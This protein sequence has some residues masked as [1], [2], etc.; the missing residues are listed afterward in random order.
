MATDAWGE[1]ISVGDK[2][3]AG[4]EIRLQGSSK[5]T[6]VIGQTPHLMDDA[7]LIAHGSFDARFL[8]LAG[9]TM[10]GAIAMGSNKITGLGSG[11]AAGDAVNVGQVVSALSA[12]LLLAGGTMAGAINMGANAL[13][14]AAT[15]GVGQATVQSGFLLDVGGSI[16][17]DGGA[18]TS[19]TTRNGSLCPWTDKRF[20]IE[21]HYDGSDYAL[22]VFGGNEAGDVDAIRFGSYAANEAQQGNFNELAVLKKDGKFGVGLTPTELIHSNAK[23]RADGVFNHNGTDGATGSFDPTAISNVNVSGGLVTGWS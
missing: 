19:S 4:G 21:L 10:S 8:K 18:S 17:A 23:I 12:Y 7:D 3:L 1:T 5:S 16:L 15:L 20:G 2:V 14:N 13:V 11:V 22:A 6:V 9:G